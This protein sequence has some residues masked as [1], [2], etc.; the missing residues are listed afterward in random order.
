M[1]ARMAANKSTLHFTGNY[2]LPEMML[3]PHPPPFK[4][5]QERRVGR[6]SLQAHTTSA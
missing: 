2:A 4:P 5:G 6:Q 3:S 1:A